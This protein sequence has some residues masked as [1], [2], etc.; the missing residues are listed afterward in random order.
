MISDE[1]I[2]SSSTT[3]TSIHL[4]SVCTSDLTGHGC[5]ATNEGESGNIEVLSAKAKSKEIETQKAMLEYDLLVYQKQ[6]Q[7][8]VQTDEK[9]LSGK[10]KIRK[11]FFKSAPC[12]SFKAREKEQGQARLLKDAYERHH[13]VQIPL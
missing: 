1:T 5:I 8:F 12:A 9:L 7:Y 2:T 13:C 11:Y 6:L 3:G 10:Y 4:G